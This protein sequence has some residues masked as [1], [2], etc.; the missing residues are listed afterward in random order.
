MKTTTY[1]WLILLFPLVGTILIG[2]GYKRLGQ[3]SGWIASLAIALS[4]AA[5]VGAL[6]S[7]LGHSE[8]HR[9]LTSSLWNYDVSVGVD[10][11]LQILVDPLSV[12][13]CLVVS[14]VSTCHRRVP[15][16]GS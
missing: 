7:L 2:L 4:F 12:F 13:M 15:V 5:A 6:L 1:G 9:E 16:A 8:A 14:G 10:S 11:K 3:A